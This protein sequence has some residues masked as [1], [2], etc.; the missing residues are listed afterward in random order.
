LGGKRHTQQS[1]NAVGLLREK[2]LQ[3]KDKMK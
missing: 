1:K 3:I 2:W